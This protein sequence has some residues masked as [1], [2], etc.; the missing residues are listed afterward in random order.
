MNRSSSLV[1]AVTWGGLLHLLLLLLP[2][3]PLG[4]EGGGVSAQGGRRTGIGAGRIGESGS[5][6]G[7]SSMNMLLMKLR[8]GGEGGVSTSSSADAAV[9][10]TGKD[11][12]AEEI[13][14]AENDEEESDDDKEEEETTT[15]AEGNK[16]DGEEEYNDDDEEEEE[17]EEETNQEVTSSVAVISSEQAHSLRLQ[18]KQ[19]H[20][21]GE[22]EVAADLFSQAA[23]ALLLLIP[24][25]SSSSEEEEEEEDP[26]DEEKASKTVEEYATCRLHQA[27]CYLKSHHYEQC[28]E[29]CSELLESNS[30]PMT[31]NA[32]TTITTTTTTPTNHATRPVVPYSSAIRARAYHRRAK[33]RLGLDMPTLA[34]DDA[35]AAAFL[36]DAKAVQLYG[37]LMRQWGGGGSSSSDDGGASSSSDG[38]LQALLS[39]STA[40]TTNNGDTSSSSAFSPASLLFGGAGSNGNLASSLLNTLTGSSKGSASGT[41]SSSLASS[42]LKSLAKRLDDPTTHTSVASFLQQTTKTQLSQYA[43]MAGLAIP[44]VYLEQVAALCQAVT[45]RKILWT[46]KLSKVVIFITQF[47]RRVAKIMR[48]YR[49][50]ILCLVLLQWT[51][52]AILR[53]IPVDRVASKKAARH[54]LTKAFKDSAGGKK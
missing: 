53:P 40:T 32:E 8:G 4:I 22:F 9:E 41:A 21:Q 35:R 38:L 36:G 26:E 1:R 14:V 34:L 11:G 17:E 45:A 16:E 51:K 18:G 3:A 42:V 20:D 5:G 31:T 52:S 7:S 10:Q 44:D 23:Q 43:T 19:A 47:V 27:L 29:T 50:L 2:F 28:L 49:S 13:E 12:G 54:E 48:K 24:P 39:K 15:T 46:I 33:A 37:K 6:S 25:I 30:T